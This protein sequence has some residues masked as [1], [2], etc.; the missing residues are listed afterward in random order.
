MDSELGPIPEG[1]GVKGLD[2]IAT[3]LNG[4]ALQK[5]P[6]IGSESLP[7]IKIAQLRAG[8]TTGA[9]SAAANLP[10]EYV[11]E[12]GDVL[13]VVRLSRMCSVDGR[14]GALKPSVQ[15]DICRLPEVGSS[16]CGFR[17]TWTGSAK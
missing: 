6:P 14:R 10:Q 17:N 3:F 13:F 2:D 15:C 8:E 9:D 5:Y 11:V 16:S 7:V 1:W 4:L 12:D